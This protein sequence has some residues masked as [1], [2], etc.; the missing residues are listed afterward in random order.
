MIY[1]LTFL[2]L[3]VIFN[4]LSGS[5]TWFPKSSQAAFLASLVE[6]LALSKNQ[7]HS[8]LILAYTMKNVNAVNVL[9]QS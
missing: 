8:E 9:P 2:I 1:Q 5:F 6:N 3:L 4:F 7:I